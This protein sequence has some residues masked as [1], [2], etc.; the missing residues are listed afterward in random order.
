[1]HSSITLTPPL[2]ESVSDIQERSAE[3]SSQKPERSVDITNMPLVRPYGQAAPKRARTT[4]TQ[5]GART[6]KRRSVIPRPLTSIAGTAFPLRLQNTMRYT[7]TVDITLNGSGTASYLFSC[8]GLYDP[9]I[10][11]TGHQPLY[12]DQ[13]TAL[14]NHYKVIRSTMVVQPMVAEGLSV[15]N[16]QS[17]VLNL[18]TDDDATLTSGSSERWDS[19]GQVVTL[20]A[21][22][23]PK[24]AITWKAD[25]VFGGNVIDN[26]DLQGNASSNPS[27]QTYFVLNTTSGVALA[28]LRYRIEIW[29]TVIW[30]ELKSVAES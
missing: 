13:L 19:R 3:R 26:P 22:Q 12:F 11:G 7:E 27:E 23:A 8:N 21:S 18:Y 10:T 5:R 28:D 24:R 15:S 2:S 30:D 25:Q 16:P 29:Y 14:Y 6:R 20:T 1:M 17:H 9:N 4:S